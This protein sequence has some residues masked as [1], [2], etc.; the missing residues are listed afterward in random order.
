VR[1]AATGESN[2][3]EDAA[4]RPVR[5]E[6]VTAGYSLRLTPGDNVQLMPVHG[7]LGTDRCQEAGWLV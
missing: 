6:R 1:I 2:K 3:P 4:E 5:Y 7:I